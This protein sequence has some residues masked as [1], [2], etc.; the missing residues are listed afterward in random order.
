MTT[1]RGLR[2]AQSS[3]HTLGS[4]FSVSFGPL[5]QLER[6]LEAGG[7]YHQVQWIKSAEHT[8]GRIQLVQKEQTNPFTPKGEA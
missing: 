8:N 3:A 6:A 1:T 5:F 2:S 4:F 7:E